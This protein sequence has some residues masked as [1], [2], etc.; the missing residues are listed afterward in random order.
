MSED[1]IPYLIDE[2][3]DVIKPDCWQRGK[4]YYGE[5]LS[6]D[7]IKSAYRSRLY[8]TSPVE[9]AILIRLERLSERLDD[10]IRDHE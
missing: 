4:Y 3:G 2:Y 1:R 8:E 9:E 10:H 7:Q 6:L 5:L